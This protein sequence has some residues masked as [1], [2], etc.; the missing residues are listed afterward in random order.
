MWCRKLRQPKQYTSGIGG[1]FANQCLLS[2]LP[3]FDKNIVVWLK[4]N[5]LIGTRKTWRESAN[6][7]CKWALRIQLPY[8]FAPEIK[9]THF[10]MISYNAF[11]C[12]RVVQENHQTCF[13]VF[14]EL[15]SNTYY[16]F[17]LLKKKQIWYPNSS[18]VNSSVIWTRNL[19]NLR[20]TL[21]LLDHTFGTTGTKHWYTSIGSVCRAVGS[22]HVKLGLEHFALVNI[23]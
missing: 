17:L 2:P 23:S 19:Q 13:W 7:N 22:M 5:G 3:A 8:S 4:P 20:H 6:V 18:P 9:P 16:S 11:S 21:W 10:I 1:T 15:H 12:S 14:W